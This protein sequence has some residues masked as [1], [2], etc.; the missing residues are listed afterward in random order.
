MKE[1]IHKEN[2]DGLNQ[3]PR[4]RALF[5]QCLK[6]ADGD[7]LRAKAYYLHRLKGDH[8]PSAEELDRREK[9]PML[10]PLIILYALGTIGVLALVFGFLAGRLGWW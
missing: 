6:Q 5:E 10:A 7:E 1:S 2:P 8:G 3:E 4:D 9:W